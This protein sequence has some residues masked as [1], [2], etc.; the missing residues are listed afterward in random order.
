MT[1]APTD[2]RILSIAREIVATE[3]LDALSFD[4]IAERLGRSKQAVLY[5]YPSKQALLS[6]LFL[7]WL[8]AEAEAARRAVEGATTPQEAIAAFVRAVAAFHMDDLERFRLMYVVPQTTGGRRRKSPD[9]DLLGKVHPVTDTLYASLA[10]R[11]APAGSASARAEAFA[12][13]ASVLGLVMMYALSDRLD[14]PLKHPPE[15]AI[16]ALLARLGAV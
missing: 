15:A 7:P 12:I 6:A 10:D 11:I 3:G 14:D 4:A 16:E 8:E 13:H 9:P 5:W 2:E 1:S